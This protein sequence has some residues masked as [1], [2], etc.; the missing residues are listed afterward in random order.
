MENVMGV[1]EARRTLGRLIRRIVETGEEV[2]IT[3]RAREKV[4]MM[5]YEEYK[6]LRELAAE[7]SAAKVSEALVRIRTAVREAGLSAGVVDDALREVR[8][9]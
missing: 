3:R 6:K 1:E 8:S 9:R 7:A 4:V 2:V 5:D